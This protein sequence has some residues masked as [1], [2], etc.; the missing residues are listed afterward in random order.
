[1]TILPQKAILAIAA[2]VDIA[3]HSKDRPVSAKAL[4]ARHALPPRHLEPV[5]QAFVREGLLRGV[6]GPGGGYALARDPRDITAQ[7]ILR[8]AGTVED[9]APEFEA[10]SH[11][12]G[13]FVVPAI[14]KAEKL[15]SD[16]LSQVRVADMIHPHTLA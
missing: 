1:M 11:L 8:A 13:E 14:A 3:V 5:L 6:R 2:V 16:A 15:F 12:I 7:E 4:A 9:A 10:T